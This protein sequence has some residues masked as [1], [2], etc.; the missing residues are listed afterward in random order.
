MNWTQ[1][2]T[3]PR[4]K[5]RFSGSQPWIEG[6]TMNSAPVVV[7]AEYE[8]DLRIYLT[9]NDGVEATVDFRDW[10]SGPLSN[11]LKDRDYFA[12]FFV[13]GGTVTW[14]NGAD[15]APETLHERAKANQVG[16]LQRLGRRPRR[17]LHGKASDRRKA[18][19]EQPDTV[20]IH[21]SEWKW[22]DIE[23]SVAECRKATWHREKWKPTPALVD[24]KGGS[25]T[26]Y[27]GQQCDPSK[28]DLVQDGWTPAPSWPRRV[29]RTRV[30]RRREGQRPRLAHGPSAPSLADRLL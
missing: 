20:L 22:T 13:E 1:T 14:P 10:L 2:G 26:L 19:I 11:R 3:V 16:R 27:V 17:R 25:V 21:G 12:R 15:I 18:R 24:K 6:A 5:S 4:A 9:F 30:H 8:G 23:E 29:G 28:A 7:S